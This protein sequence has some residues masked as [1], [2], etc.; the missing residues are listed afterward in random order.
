MRAEGHSGRGNGLVDWPY[1]TLAGA[2]AAGITEADFPPG[3]RSEA[4]GDVE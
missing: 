4:G 1:K 2:L 3:A